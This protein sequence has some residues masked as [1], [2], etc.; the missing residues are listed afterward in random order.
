VTWCA[1]SS[2]I[3]PATA[4]RRNE[5]GKMIF[6]FVVLRCAAAPLREKSS[7]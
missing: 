7:L 2:K 4:Q 1:Y 3:S 5:E 6:A